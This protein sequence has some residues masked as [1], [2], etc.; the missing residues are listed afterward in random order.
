MLPSFFKIHNRILLTFSWP[1]II[2]SDLIPD[3]FASYDHDGDLKHYHVEY[4]G[5]P[6]SHSWVLARNVE[7]YGSGSAPAPSVL[8]SSKGMAS[9]RA[10]KSFE[11]AVI[12]AD[13]MTS[14]KPKERL[15]YC[16][17]KA[18]PDQTQLKRYTE[19]KCCYEVYSHHT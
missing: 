15:K 12:Q 4:F 5:E 10:R 7:M 9:A 13:G 19:S 6:R 8:A 16:T 2:C 17:F 11:K 18:M 1:A 3:N 14:L